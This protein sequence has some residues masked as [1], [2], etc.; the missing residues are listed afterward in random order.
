LHNKPGVDP[1][2]FCGGGAHFVDIY[3]DQLHWSSDFSSNFLCKLKLYLCKI[4][5]IFPNMFMILFIS[6]NVIK[7][8]IDKK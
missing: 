8:G 3:V 6:K 5:S 1:G 2:I 4:K 7:I